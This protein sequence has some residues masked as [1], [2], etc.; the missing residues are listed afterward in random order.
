MGEARINGVGVRYYGELAAEDNQLLG[1]AVLEGVLSAIF[2][3]A[4]SQPV[5]A[6]T[7]AGERGIELIESR[8]TR[9]GITRASSR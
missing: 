8:S 3:L 7:V 9:R 1:S 2:R 6:S 4:A 5:N